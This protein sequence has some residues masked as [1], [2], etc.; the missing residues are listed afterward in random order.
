MPQGLEIK[1]VI[2]VYQAVIFIMC[3]L[4]FLLQIM[5]QIILNEF[6]VYALLH[7]LNHLL[8]LLATG[9]VLINGMKKNKVILA[10]LFSLFSLA[11]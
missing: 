2:L 3:F 11:F 9:R 1:G 7:R 5:E 6:K 10:L 4:I 8:A